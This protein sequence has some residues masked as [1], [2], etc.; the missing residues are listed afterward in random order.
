MSGRGENVTPGAIGMLVL[1]SLLP[2][3]V[4]VL[5]LG[6]LPF[7]LMPIIILLAGILFRD[8]AS[9]PGSSGPEGGGGDEPPEPDQPPD[10]PRGGLPLPDADPAR[11]RLRHHR[12]HDRPGRI[13]GRSRRAGREPARTGDLSTR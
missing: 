6:M 5:G 10:V 3:L 8:Q 13:P 11:G 2:A 7:L 9:P 1:V 12:D 4:V